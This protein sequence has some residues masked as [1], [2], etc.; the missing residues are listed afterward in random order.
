MAVEEWFWLTRRTGRKE[1]V[2]VLP[3]EVVHWFRE[4]IGI[5]ISLVQPRCLHKAS[6]MRE[7]TLMQSIRK[8]SHFQ[9]WPT[10]I[11]SRFLQIGRGKQVNVIIAE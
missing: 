11:S 5:F 7:L 10:V 6:T 8:S 2:I 3:A 4:R 9:D 1:V